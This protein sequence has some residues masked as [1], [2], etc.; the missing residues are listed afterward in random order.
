MSNTDIKDV[1]VRTEKEHEA[2]LKEVKETQ[3][4]V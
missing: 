1:V 3:I 4:K 2:K